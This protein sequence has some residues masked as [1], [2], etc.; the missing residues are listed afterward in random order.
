MLIERIATCLERAGR[1]ETKISWSAPNRERRIIADVASLAERVVDCEPPAAVETLRELSFWLASLAR[2]P[3]WSDDLPHDLFLAMLS[4]ETRDLAICTGLLSVGISLGG[5]WPTPWPEMLDEDE[6]TRL[7]DLLRRDGARL[8]Q[9]ARGLRDDLDRVARLRD[10]A[11]RL[12]RVVAG[13][14]L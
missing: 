3:H 10:A 12:R 4:M 13:V 11:S 1:G 2:H 14:E 7:L 8:E 6:E 9:L 5:R